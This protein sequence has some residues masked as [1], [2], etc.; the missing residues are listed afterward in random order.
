VES[1]PAEEDQAPY[2]HKDFV[3]HNPIIWAHMIEARGKARVAVALL[4]QPM[5][6]QTSMGYCSKGAQGG[7]NTYQ[8]WK[9]TEPITVNRMPS[10]LTIC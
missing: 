4:C 3:Q 9:L 8:L 1:D 6:S 7:L 5:P 10:Y 2:A